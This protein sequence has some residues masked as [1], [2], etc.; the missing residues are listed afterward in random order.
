VQ[1][2][3]AAARSLAGSGLIAGPDPTAN[4]RPHSGY[5]VPVNRALVL[6]AT[7]LVLNFRYL[8][9][10]DLDRSRR[11]RYSVLSHVDRRSLTLAG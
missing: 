1:S 5:L 7:A 10:R 6:Y 3:N 8:C 11:G 2:E 9:A 4:L